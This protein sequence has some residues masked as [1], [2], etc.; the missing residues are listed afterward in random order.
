MDGAIFDITDRRAAEEEQ[1]RREIEEARAE[2]LRASRVRIVQAADAAR[3]KI[4]RDLHDGAQQRL[5]ALALQVRV[6]RTQVEKDPATAGPFLDQLGDE[7]TEASAE[8]R[9]LARGIHPA[10]L[11]DRGLAAAIAA[12]AT[13][14]PVPVEIL[15][16]PG[17]RLPGPI[18]AAAYFTVAEA[19]TNVAKYAQATHATVRAVC[20]DGRL[21]VE[22]RDDG[23]GGAQ[24]GTGSGLTGLTDRLGA[25]DG[26]L[27]VTS[28]PGEGT[29]IRALLPLTQGSSRS[30]A[31]PG[32][33]ATSRTR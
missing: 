31:P 7:L 18:E 12:L 6:A 22:I 17:E 10:V 16:L 27:N 8:L 14:A 23:I 13:R 32:T 2:E 5:V 28:P 24:A 30:P 15:D 26:S 9:E 20:E 19:L 4:E 33:P 29:L 1:R 25:C 11:T 21:V 3:R